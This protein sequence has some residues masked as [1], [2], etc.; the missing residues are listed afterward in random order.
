MKRVFPLLAFL[1]LI[2]G[3]G[4]YPPPPVDL[5]GL[6]IPR[7]E[8]ITFLGHASA[9]IDWEDVVLITDPVYDDS[10]SP[11][12]PRISP[13]PGPAMF[14]DA[15]LVLISHAHPDHLSPKT[16]SRFPESAVILCP[17]PAAE[18]VVGLGPSVRIM[19]PGEAYGVGRVTVI[20]VRAFHAGGR[21]S[22]E[23]DGDGRALG[24]VIQVRDRTL[25]YSG[26]TEFF[27]GIPEIGTR[28]APDLLL[29]NINS[30]LEGHD[31]V[32][33]VQALGAAPVISLHHSAY[34]GSN[35]RRRE[36]WN[37]ELSDTL[38]RLFLIPEVGEGFPMD[39]VR[40]SPAETLDALW[41]SR[42]D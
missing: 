24:Y 19:R 23:Q 21:A 17:P 13:A 26:D 35:E 3:C 33:A 37:A 22:L 6:R 31:A 38:G 5:D 4:S 25:Y 12:H 30:H 8:T 10:Y 36:D 2:T 11:F 40:D 15:N 29:L 39:A 9:R 1:L 27:E 16:L 7:E 18:H 20:A 32:M 42:G 14:D 34:G 28:H 41:A